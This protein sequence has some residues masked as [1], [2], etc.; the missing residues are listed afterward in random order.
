MADKSIHLDTGMIDE[1]S[2]I[3]QCD[4]LL[5]L[6]LLIQGLAGPFVQIALWKTSNAFKI[7]FGS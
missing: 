3:C 1:T 4:V 6:P 7:V 2:V 5:C